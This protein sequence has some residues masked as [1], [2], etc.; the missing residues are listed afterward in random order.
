MRIELIFFLLSLGSSVGTAGVE[1]T[2]FYNNSYYNRSQRLCTAKGRYTQTHLGLSGARVCRQDNGFC[3]MCENSC[4]LDPRWSRGWIPHTE[5]SLTPCAHTLCDCGDSSLEKTKTNVKQEI[6]QRKK[7]QHFHFHYPESYR[8]RYN[9]QFVFF[10][11][12]TA[13]IFENSRC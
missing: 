2:N 7:K 3:Y 11:Q 13:L 10:S 8:V 4:W 6:G 5:T 1:S 12:I 9:T